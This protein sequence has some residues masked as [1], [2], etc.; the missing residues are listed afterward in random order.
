MVYIL[1]VAYILIIVTHPPICVM[2]PDDIDLQIIDI[3]RA[4]ARTPYTEIARRLGVSEATVRRRIRSLEERG[5]ITGYTAVVEP[6]K[7]GFSTVAMLGIN[8]TPDRFLEVAEELM[9]FREV[10]WLATSTGDH[11]ILA[12]VWTKDGKELTELISRR[13]GRIDGITHIRPAIILEK[14]KKA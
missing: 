7:L 12:E 1:F 3:L 9:K 5:V 13:M 11:M 4:D 8:T 6:A 14:L 2:Q 10:K